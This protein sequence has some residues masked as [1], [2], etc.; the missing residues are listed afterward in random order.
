MLRLVLVLL[1]ILF[2]TAPA[3]AGP[4][5][6]PGTKEVARG[7]RWKV[8]KRPD[9]S[10]ELLTSAGAMHWLDPD[11]NT[12]VDYDT[13]FIPGDNPGEFQAA[14][15]PFQLSFHVGKGERV[16]ATVGP[17]DR[18]WATI[19]L[20]PRPTTVDA[21]SF[22][23]LYDED[24]PC[25]YVIT[26]TGVKLDCFVQKPQ[27]RKLY[28][29]D[30]RTEGPV[31]VLREMADGGL[32]NSGSLFMPR[33]KVYGAN[34][35]TYEA[36][37]WEV[38]KSGHRIA[39]LWDD[40]KLP[41]EA[42]PYHIDPTINAPGLSDDGYV[43]GG[44]AVYST[45]RTTSDR[46][47]DSENEIYVGQRY[48]G[49]PDFIYIIWRGLLSFDTSAIGSGSTVTQAKV[50][51]RVLG[52]GSE[53]DFDVQVRKFDWSSPMAFGN[54]ETNYDGC[55]VATYDNQWQNTS[56]ISDGNYYGSN[57]LDN[58]WVNKTGTTRYCLT[59]SRDANGNPPV[60]PT[61]GPSNANEY[62]V[63]ASTNSSYDPYL[64]VIY[65]TGATPT[66]SHTPVNTATNTIT[67][68][69]THTLTPPAETATFTPT[70]P[71]R[72]PTPTCA[73]VRGQL[74]INHTLSQY[75]S[76]SPATG[77]WG[78]T[79]FTAEGWFMFPLGGVYTDR[80][81]F[82]RWNPNTPGA[83]GFLISTCCG[84]DDNA[85]VVRVGGSPVL[86]PEGDWS[87]R[88]ASYRYSLGQFVHLALV[89]D[90]TVPEVRF[91]VNGELQPLTTIGIV[92]ST[93][94]DPGVAFE[95]GS[96]PSRT[97]YIPTALDEVRFYTGRAKSG[98]EIAADYAATTSCGSSSDSNLWFGFH[99]DQSSGSVVNDY[100]TNNN[101][102]A[103][104]N[105]PVWAPGSGPVCCGGTPIPTFSPTPV[106]TSTS[107]PLG[108]S[109]TPTGPS[110]TRTYTKTFTLPPTTTATPGGPTATPGVRF[111]PAY[112]TKLCRGGTNQG[113]PC[114]IDAD[115]PGTGA[116]CTI[117]GHRRACISQR[118]CNISNTLCVDNQDCPLWPSDMRDF[119]PWPG[120]CRGGTS[121]AGITGTS[122]CSAVGGEIWIERR[123]A[124]TTDADCGICASGPLSGASCTSSADCGGY[125]CDM[126]QGYCTEGLNQCQADFVYQVGL[127]NDAIADYSIGSPTVESCRVGA[128][129]PQSVGGP[130]GVY[131]ESSRPSLLVADHTA[132]QNRIS[133]FNGP[134]TTNFPSASYFWG[135]YNSVLSYWNGLPGDLSTLDNDSVVPNR[136][137]GGQGLVKRSMSRRNG[138]GGYVWVTD[139][140]RVLGFDPSATTNALAATALGVPVGDAEFDN[141]C[142]QS[143]TIQNYMCYATGVSAIRLCSNNRTIVCDED[144]DCSGGGTCKEAVAVSDYGQNRVL[145]Y[146][147]SLGPGADADIV[148]GQSGFGTFGSPLNS[149]NRGTTVAANSLCNPISVFWDSSGNLWVADMSNNRVLRYNAGFSS[150]ANASVVLGQPDMTTTSAGTTQAKMHA[151]HEVSQLSGGGILVADT[152]NDRV[153]V[154]TGALSSGM[155]ASKV[156]GQFSYTGGEGALSSNGL[157]CDRLF[158]PKGLSVDT[159][160]DT[161]YV[162][163]SG[164]MRVLVFNWTGMP[165]FGANAAFRIGQPTCAAWHQNL[166]STD[167]FNGMGNIG[168]VAV[169]PNGGGCFGDST[170]HRILCWNDWR[171]AIARGSHASPTTKQADTIIGQASGFAS[172]G[173]PNWL[174]NRGG[175]PTIATL[176]QPALFSATTSSLFIPDRG[177][178][179][180]LRFS[181][182]LPLGSLPNPAELIGQSSPS[183][184]TPGTSATQFN[185]PRAAKADAYGNLW[186][187]DENNGRVLLFCRVPNT[188]CKFGSC[189][190]TGANSAD[191]VADIVL[192][193]TDFTQSFSGPLCARPE[194]TT[195]CTA[196][197]VVYD[198]INARVF[199][200]DASHVRYCL[201]HGPLISCNSDA[202]CSGA[203]CAEGGG[204]VLIYD[205]P[206]TNGKAATT[207]LGIS[208]GSMNTYTG[209]WAGRCRGGTHPG[210]LCY[211]HND[212]ILAM[213]WP[214][215]VRAEKCTGR[216]AGQQA[217]WGNESE[218][219]GA[220][221]SAPKPTPTPTEDAW[222][223]GLF[224]ETSYCGCG[225]GGV[226]EWAAAG[227][228]PST[229]AYDFARNILFV[230]RSGGVQRWDSPFSS[231]MYSKEVYGKTRPHFFP[232]SSSG[233]TG[234]QW[235]YAGGG[236]FLTAERDLLVVMGETSDSQTGVLGMM[237]P[238][239]PLVGTPTTIPTA[240]KTITPGGP[241]TPTHTYT[242]T[243]TITP[244]PS[245]TPPATATH[246]R[247]ITPGGPPT[248]TWTLVATAAPTPTLA[249]C[250]DASTGSWLYTCTLQPG[251]TLIADT[252]RVASFKGPF[253]TLE[254]W[255]AGSLEVSPDGTLC[256]GPI[257]QTIGASPT[258]PV[259]PVFQ[260]SPGGVLNGSRTLGPGTVNSSLR[261]SI[262]LNSNS[263]SPTGP[264]GANVVCQ[265]RGPNEAPNDLWGAY[266]V[267]YTTT[268]P[269][270][271]V[272]G[273]YPTL[274]NVTCNGSCVAGATLY[275]RMNFFSVNQ[276]SNTRILSIQAEREAFAGGPLEWP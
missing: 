170:N 36:G 69:P 19:F 200:A 202:D 62:L 190:C 235:S 45:A 145:V 11:S 124:C 167:T 125:L 80:S 141:G 239:P 79:K 17:L 194:A 127:P 249:P 1:A 149:C 198:H 186:V 154:F 71:T 164:N 184:T 26:K 22:T 156:I 195:V 40:S 274:S 108:A 257:P 98:S 261:F 236:L 61:P 178:N 139:Q 86:P 112:Q 192:G 162:A 118:R 122:A 14:N 273:V 232:D 72:T 55:L 111:T 209:S 38:S 116:I 67:P 176:N 147:S 264:V 23:F 83:H 205:L 27:G 227:L 137:G 92:P 241:S 171:D 100:S 41:P 252:E 135:A 84:V 189:N 203:T 5:F 82:G 74:G 247:T 76:V 142:S 210:E 165:E 197:D 150:G 201:R 269:A 35:I 208:G 110:P 225:P 107:T 90:G 12:W 191:W 42:Y 242:R 224:S 89:W 238:G 240:T 275:W 106:P 58:S 7:E 73:G 230:G 172:E 185:N 121:T 39:F 214:G 220:N 104:H 259:V 173:V 54:Q 140:S 169:L 63:I 13:N 10:M 262:T 37:P 131:Y 93:V 166:V 248:P 157:Y 270:Q 129:N 126:T 276:P 134:I 199:V 32:N 132:N 81:F 152:R 114:Q 161:I 148:L 215:G 271:Y 143:V 70:G 65:T 266:G 75:V 2:A 52:D 6:S 105:S 30:T 60:T 33:P 123:E 180:I 260:C 18:S 155:N 265:C 251:Q 51:L 91:Y 219:L 136:F 234:C 168:G 231:G 29:F 46:Y 183:V 102:G 263:G 217:T 246:T 109:P 88:T 222:C 196:Q 212:N 113:Y 103:A 218:L 245:A 243:P 188:V 254:Q 233:Y 119:C 163:D 179:R 255:P 159:S 48:M 256:S 95:I 97:S 174:A 206:L 213:G 237:E 268:L 204:R 229:L 120:F 133:V 244:N 15:V 47:S 28:K 57:A 153:L 128:I 9:G 253:N 34:G 68:T 158:E 187:A 115:C 207:V 250:F 223:D 181:L 66:P 44:N 160:T 21:E 50:Y 99:F 31:S 175:T 53:T 193:K 117:L 4:T 20:I 267:I 177:N 94:L 151:P 85:F 43:G 130:L 24:T 221:C 77:S 87:G 146:H 25:R 258:S 101:D 49:T 96:M 272:N 8:G 211:Q 144:G 64:E 56:A 16:E 226:C 228:T 182:P 216:L 59:S 3:H 138:T 78:T